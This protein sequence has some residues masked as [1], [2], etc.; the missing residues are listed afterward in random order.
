LEV[1][2]N[3]PVS[4]EKVFSFVG[5][6]E[7]HKGVDL[8]IDLAPLFPDYKFKLIGTGSLMAEFTNKKI[9]NLEILGYQTSENVSKIIASSAAV[10]IPS[11]CYENSP[12]VIYEA[13][14]VK[15]PTIAANLGGIPE[16]INKFGGL[17]FT[18]DNLESLKEA[19]NTLIKDGVKLKENIPDPNYSQTVID[20]IG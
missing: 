10:I 11:R 1:K 13:Y 6:L 2:S 9:N 19:V 12:T 20:K 8:F 3:Q 18:P 17:L 4:K 14:A 16:L 5:Q 7:Y 15:T